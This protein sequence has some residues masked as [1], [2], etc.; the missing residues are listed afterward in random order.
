[1][2]WTWGCASRTPC[3]CS[4][5]LRDPSSQWI[6]CAR[7]TRMFSIGQ[8]N[9]YPLNPQLSGSSLVKFNLCLYTT[10]RRE[11]VLL[12]CL[13]SLPRRQEEV[14]MER[15][16]GRREGGE[17]EHQSPS[18][19][20]WLQTAAESCPLSIKPWCLFQNNL[21]HT[22]KPAV[23]HYN[24]SLKRHSSCQSKWA[25][26]SQGAKMDCCYF[27]LP[28]LLWMFIAHLR[29]APGNSQWIA[30][31]VRSIIKLEVVFLGYKYRSGRELQETGSGLC[32]VAREA[33]EAS[34]M[35]HTGVLMCILRTQGHLI[36]GTQQLCHLS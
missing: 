25:I 33:W 1:M 12:C 13:S 7:E 30:L 32:H 2:V 6:R 10:P 34:L 23:R 28:L 21:Q 3:L 9:T 19:R 27:F 15:E 11:N 31:P 24:L 29:L 26:Y 8:L 36:E 20:S 18:F 35:S 17:W 5:V 16:Q 4:T 14:D 22:T